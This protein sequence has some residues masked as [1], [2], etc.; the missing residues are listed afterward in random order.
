L[1]TRERLFELRDKR[2]QSA[3]DCI[4]NAIFLQMHLRTSY[5]LVPEIAA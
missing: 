1:K 2:W 3:D 4:P 5:H